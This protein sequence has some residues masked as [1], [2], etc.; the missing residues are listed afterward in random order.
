ML[1]NHGLNAAAG[2]YLE[3]TTELHAHVEHADVHHNRLTGRGGGIL[4]EMQVEAAKF[5]L[6]IYNSRFTHNVVS[7]CVSVPRV[8]RH[9]AG[10]GALKTALWQAAIHIRFSATHSNVICNQTAPHLVVT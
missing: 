10:G 9:L 5:V 3:S 4:A 6:S 7:C 2:I 1:H 8:T